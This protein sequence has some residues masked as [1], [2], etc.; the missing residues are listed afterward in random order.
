LASENQSPWAIVW[1]CLCNPVFSRFSRIP[2]CDR[3]T[4]TDRHRHR[5]MD[6]TTDARHRVVKNFLKSI[7]KSFTLSVYQA[8]SI[9]NQACS[10]CICILYHVY[11]GGIVAQR[12]GVGLAIKRSRVQSQVL[13]LNDCGQVVH[14]HVPLS[15][16]NIL[17]YR[18]KSLG[19]NGR[20]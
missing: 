12:E 20:L 18:C 16:S 7:N 19:G 10:N 14:T 15:A 3:Q 4:Q 8:R 9:Q 11:L 1:C 17:W 6:S 13:L 2:T 5:P